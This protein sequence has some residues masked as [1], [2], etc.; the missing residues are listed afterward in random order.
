MSLKSRLTKLEGVRVVTSNQ[1]EEFD[2]AL[3]ILTRKANGEEITPE[4]WQY[5]NQL[6]WRDYPKELLLEARRK[7]NESLEETE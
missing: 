3:K 2:Q 5:Y 4:E 1:I 7:V 6:D